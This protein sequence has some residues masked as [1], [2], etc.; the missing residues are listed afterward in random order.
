LVLR[1]SGLPALWG[2]VSG[3]VSVLGGALAGLLGPVW[4]VVAGVTALAG[5]ALLIWHYWEQVKAFML[6]TFRALWAGLAPVRES[7][8]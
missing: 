4:A 3:A 1:L 7:I 5:G 6:G 8:A 2:M